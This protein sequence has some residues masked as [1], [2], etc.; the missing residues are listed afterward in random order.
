MGGVGIPLPHPPNR[1]KKEKMKSLIIGKGQI[2]SALY[3]ILKRK[4]DVTIRD[5]EHITLHDVQFL[6]ICYPDQTNFV[7]ITKD[8]IETY[9]PWVTIIHSSVKVGTTDKIGS[10]VVYCPIRGRH[11]NLELEIPMY[12]IFIAG[13]NGDNVEKVRQYLEPSFQRIHVSYDPKSLELIKLLSNIH[14]GLEIAWRQEVTRLFDHF[15]C[16]SLIYNR[17][18]D[19]YNEGYRCTNQENLIRPRMQDHKIGGHCIIPCT[20][21]LN[22]Q[23][24]SLAFEFILRGNSKQV[25]KEMEA[26]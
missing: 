2:G 4:H 7:E 3:E 23:F 10:H 24:P 15:E 20:Q 26:V 13:R 25:M 6:H 12:Q 8:Y 11:P 21:I 16:D 9:R 18:E 17:W 22:E 5:V 14:M 1:I 19:S